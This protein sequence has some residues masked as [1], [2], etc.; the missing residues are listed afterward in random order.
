MVM[1][2]LVNV[3]THLAMTLYRGMAEDLVLQDWLNKLWPVEEKFTRP[4][5]TAL[6][7]S[8]ALCEM[9]RGGITTALDM[10]W[11]P[12]I[13]ARTA[14]QA[15]FRLG[16]GPVFFDPPGADH[17]SQPQRFIAA[18]AFFEEF[19]GNPMIIPCVQAHGTY[20][21]GP[22]N[23]VKAF[24]V[25]QQAGALFQTHASETRGEVEMVRK[26][27]GCSPVE[28][29]HHLGLLGSTTVL[30]HCVH[31]GE[32]EIGLLAASGTGVSHNPLS[33]FK[34]ASGVAPVVKM[35]KAGV[36]SGLGTDGACSGNDLDLWKAMR[37]AA[38]MQKT[39]HKDPTVATARQMVRMAT[40][41][42]AGVLGMEKQIGSLETGK[43]ADLILI[44]MNRPHLTPLYDVYPQLVYAVGRDDVRTVLIHGRL[45]MQDGVLLTLDE[46][47][48][49]A[50]MGAFARLAAG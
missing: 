18:Q 1:P 39:I 17:L 32:D 10:Y 34:L 2:G 7:V 30:A 6:G 33:N 28:H 11:L 47:K 3:H 25:A 49:L 27:Y 12:E 4:Q 19:G 40:I 46:E 35:L 43:L 45:V 23:L 5:T 16:A 44:D 50:E 48:I 24:A 38:L 42:G 22:E 29:L 26:Q 13:A 14:L 9:L 21:V 41:E 15:G 8:L 31:I 37:M 20:T 36:K